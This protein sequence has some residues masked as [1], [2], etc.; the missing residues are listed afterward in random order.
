MCHQKRWH[1][2]KLNVFREGVDK[3]LLTFKL[4][5]FVVLQ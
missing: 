2:V 5:V 1:I 4:F 3:S